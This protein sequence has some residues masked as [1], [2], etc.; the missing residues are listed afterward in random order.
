MFVAASG[1]SEDID[2][3]SA[4]AEVREQCEAAMEG[5]PPQAGLLFAGMDFEHQELL[6]AISDAWPGIELIGCTTDGELSSCL[7]FRDDSISLLLL[8]SDTI[9][10]ATGLG[11]GLS[12]DAETACKQ[13]VKQ[14]RAKIELEPRLCIVLP[15]SLNISGQKT[16]EALS[17]ALGEDVD[18]FGGRAADHRKYESTRQ[19]CGREVVSDSV[20]I[21][22][23]SGPLFYSFGVASGWKPIGDPG[24]ITRSQG[25]VVYKI[26]GAPAVEFYH[27]FLG[28]EFKLSADIPLII[29]NDEGKPEYL[30]PSSGEVDEE[31]GA[32]TYLS[33]VPE[34][35]RAQI[36]ITDRAAILEG[37]EEAI[38]K[39]LQGFPDIKKPE[40]AV[41][42]SCSARKLL[43]GTKTSEEFRIVREKIGQ[44]IP[45]CGF[46]SFGEI[47]PQKTDSTKPIMHHETFT[48]LLLGT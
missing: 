20:P 40:A 44:D 11:R 6:D 31:T 45:I 29:L 9:G 25:N 27:R 1:H 8:A 7:G 48:M 36:S 19:F 14:A 13:A 17:K 28:K 37:C 43:L 34:G 33:D 18:L 16:V 15:E 4:F 23:L 3:L 10:F 24:Y 21:L 39:A 26:D 35:V 41:I 47:G 22:L 32:I 38:R 46:Y 2:T 5:K 30:R 42:V 12:E